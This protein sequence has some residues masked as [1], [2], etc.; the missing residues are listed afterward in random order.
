[1]AN[2][3]RCSIAL[4]G[5]T[6]AGD[7]SLVVDFTG[8][9]VELPFTLAEVAQDRDAAKKAARLIG[10]AVVKRMKSAQVT[11]EKWDAMKPEKAKKGVE[12]W[13]TKLWKNSNS[14]R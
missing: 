6:S 8:L 2:N 10:R 1:M 4:R 7:P 9:K 13:R 5:E 3:K 12:K 11:F 14:P